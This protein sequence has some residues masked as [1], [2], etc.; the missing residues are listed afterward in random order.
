MKILINAFTCT[1]IIHIHDLRVL[2]N[3]NCKTKCC[4]IK[5]NRELEMN[6]IY[7]SCW[8]KW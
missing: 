8:Y 1:Y 2:G 7:L 4:T 3:K 5:Y 6:N